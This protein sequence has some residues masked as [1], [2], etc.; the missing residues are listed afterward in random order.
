MKKPNL[1]VLM[2][3]I[4]VLFAGCKG[5]EID[6][7]NNRLSESESR[8]SEQEISNINALEITDAQI[9]ALK[10]ELD[11]VKAEY[12]SFPLVEYKPE[13][14]R[15]LYLGCNN[16][17]NFKA[18]TRSGSEL[19][20]TLSA[21]GG[22]T[23]V[24]DSPGVFLVK[25]IAIGSLDLQRQVKLNDGSDFD[26]T[27]SSFQ[28]THEA[29]PLVSVSGF[30]DGDRISKANLTAARGITASPTLNFLTLCPNARASVTSF[31]MA[32]LLGGSFDETPSNSA[33]F[34]NLM[35]TMLKKLKP[36]S[37]VF[38][39]DIRVQMTD[40]TFRKADSISFD[41]I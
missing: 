30:V 23:I 3:L 4:L 5:D 32:T 28:V 9:A 31:K 18:T 14:G 24:E 39:R 1:F 2:S 7:L 40:G 20:T 25:P 21:V 19:T 37:Q 12:E 10:G 27:D 26:L 33:L 13:G 11:S 17:V 41:V 8:F 38:L 34:T 6:D 15:F 35:K 16:K 36:G 22:S 29:D